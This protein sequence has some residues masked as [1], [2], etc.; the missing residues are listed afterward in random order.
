MERLTWATLAT[1]KPGAFLFFTEDF[2]AEIGTGAHV[3]PA[4]TRCYITENGLD[5]IWAGI[6][7]AVA[8]KPIADLLVYAQADHNGHLLI[9]RDDLEFSPFTL[10]ETD[11][12]DWT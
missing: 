7:V 10:D 11:I 4:E 8:F 9:E 2:R 12:R 1:V 5:A 3:I 6:V